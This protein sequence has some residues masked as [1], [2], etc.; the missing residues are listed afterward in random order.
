MD[1]L[2]LDPTRYIK[3]MNIV[4]LLFNLFEKILISKSH[5][6]CP[7]EIHFYHNDSSPMPMLL[8]G[9][10]CYNLFTNSFLS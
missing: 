10:K 1:Q 9:I 2:L 5:T 8:T 3:F 7:L 6:N 4:F